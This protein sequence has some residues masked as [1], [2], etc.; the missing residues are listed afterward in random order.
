MRRK[1]DNVWMGRIRMLKNIHGY[2][3]ESAKAGYIFILIVVRSIELRSLFPALGDYFKYIRTQGASML[4]IHK[5]LYCKNDRN[6]CILYKL[7]LFHNLGS[8]THPSLFEFCAASHGMICI[9]N[10]TIYVMYEVVWLGQVGRWRE[11]YVESTHAVLLW[12]ESL[13]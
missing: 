7:G 3:F 12:P 5:T 10:C 13:Y 4:T 1:F 6:C 9:L 8:F 11:E 2:N